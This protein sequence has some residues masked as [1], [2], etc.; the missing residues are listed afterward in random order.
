M[1]DTDNSAENWLAQAEQ[2]ATGAEST[3]E[4]SA[5]IELCDRGLH[6]TPSA[7]Q[8]S[9][10]RFSR[11]GPTIGAAKSFPILNTRTPRSRIFRPQFLWIPVVR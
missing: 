7:E 4:L 2:A 6:C 11:L 8:L 1:T 3:E 10:L 5:V 9:S